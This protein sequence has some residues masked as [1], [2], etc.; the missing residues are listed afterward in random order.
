MLIPRARTRF[1]AAIAFGVSCRPHTEPQHIEVAP[2]A[3]ATATAT[4]SATASASASAA[5]SAAA[6]VTASVAVTASA[7]S[8]MICA[9]PSKKDRQCVAPNSAP[10]HGMIPPAPGYKGFDSH[11]CFP[12]TEM[13]DVCSGISD[14]RGPSFQGGACC[15]EV[16][17][18]T[19]A[20][21]GLAL[22]VDGIPR[23]AELRSGAN[24][25]EALLEHASIAAFARLSLE[26]L[27]L[28]APPELVRGAHEAALDEIEHARVLFTR[29]GAEP[30]PLRLDGLTLRDR[31]TM[32]REIARDACVGETIAALDLAHRANG[33]PMLEKMSEDELRHAALGWT[34]V[35][36]LGEPVEFP[37]IA[38]DVPAEVLEEA[39]ALVRAS[40]QAVAEAGVSALRAV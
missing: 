11:G 14:A 3:S 2:P 21:C 40:A 20:P 13:V 23:V 37:E 22:V 19:A 24:A 12:A 5:A 9:F 31:K 26:L 32:A 38:Y 6:T 36:W 28:G 8:S 35:A 7:R 34:I 27:A 16:C 18:G 1:L 10:Q 25:N 29:A 30:G 15:F 17:Q 39:R 33:D 4:A